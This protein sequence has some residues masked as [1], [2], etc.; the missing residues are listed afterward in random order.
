MKWT[1]CD[2]WWLWCRWSI[3][4]CYPRE[5]SHWDRMHCIVSSPPSSSWWIWTQ[6]LFFRWI[7]SQECDSRYHC[8]LWNSGYRA[9]QVCQVSGDRCDRH[10]SPCCSREYT[11][12]SHRN[13][14]S[15][16]QRLHLSV[17]WTRW[18]MSRF[19]VDS[20]ITYC[21]RK[22]KTMISGCWTPPC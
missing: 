4:H 7:T 13:N 8:R 14:Q 17:P 20:L 16:T 6:I 22:R 9:N 5:V 2:I 12:R 11:R 19:Q 15:K 3:E 18:C 1:N 21:S 10:W